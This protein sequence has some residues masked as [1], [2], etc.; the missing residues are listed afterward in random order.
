MATSGGIHGKVEGVSQV[1]AALQ[2]FGVEAEDLKDAHVGIAG[3]GA[4]L[5]SSFAPKD[6]GRLAGSLRPG[7]SKAR[8][9][10][11][12]RVIYAGPINYGWRR[13]NIKPALFMQRAD[14]VLAAR[15]VAM[16]DRGLDKAITKVGL[17]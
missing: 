14:A 17:E 4:R 8:S 11:T 9:F 5:A 16:L 7:T 12:S 13:R 3:E 1:L 6:S 10:V 15:A 2:R